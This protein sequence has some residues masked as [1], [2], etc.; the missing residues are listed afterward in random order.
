MSLENITKDNM[1]VIGDDINDYEML[2]EFNGAIMKEHHPKLSS[3]QK[4]E[5][6]YFYEY[7][8]ELIN[9]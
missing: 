4:K 1:Y 5:Y 7:I 6:T 9:N 2:H 3:L 8:E